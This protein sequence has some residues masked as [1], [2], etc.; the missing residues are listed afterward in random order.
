MPFDEIFVQQL[1]LVQGY[2]GSAFNRW[3]DTANAARSNTFTMAQLFEAYRLQFVDNWDTWNQIMVLPI[4]ERLP[5]I[6]LG[7]RW[8]QLTTGPASG[9]A[10]L[11][12]RLDT[13]AFNKIALQRTS[14]GNT[15]PATDYSL[16]VSGD[17]SGTVTVTMLNNIA[18]GQQPAAGVDD[19]YVGP[20]LV[21]LTGE[22]VFKPLAW[23]AVVAEP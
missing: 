9:S 2:W 11:N 20:L 15:I 22:T 1:T 7:G 14:G 4:Q 19:V 12:R 18:S 17:F 5:T 6:S 10:S 8:N 16:T 21:K 3:R 23:I 13:P